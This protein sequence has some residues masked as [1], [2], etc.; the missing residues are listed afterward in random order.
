MTRSITLAEV[1]IF[2]EQALRSVIVSVNDNGGEV[3]PAGL[4]RNGD[5]AGGGG[6]QQ[7]YSTEKTDQQSDE[8][9]DHQSSERAPVS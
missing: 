9:A 3:E 6:N 5:G 2:G 4:I 8:R 7:S 1:E